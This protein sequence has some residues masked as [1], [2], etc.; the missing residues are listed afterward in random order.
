MYI[1]P[2]CPNKQFHATVLAL[3]AR[4]ARELQRYIPRY[5]RYVIA[6]MVGLCSVPVF[7]TPPLEASL[8]QLASDSDHILAGHIIGVDMVD[9]NGKE[10]R[11]EKAMTGPRLQTTIRLIIKV[12]EIFFSRAKAVP[13]TIRVPLDPMMHF[14][15]G[16]IKEAHREPSRS[17]LVILQGGSFE[18]VVPGVFFRELSDAQK[19][20][21]IR[22]RVQGSNK[23]IEPTR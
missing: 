14:S 13:D 5:M 2:L 3:R 7:A 21:E 19:A 22:A 18:P 20:L 16:Q 23:T 15:L 1:Q 12:D 9:A 11:D 17:M 10:V 4:P 8:E 6:L